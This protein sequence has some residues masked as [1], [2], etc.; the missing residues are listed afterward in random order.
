M[1]TRPARSFER[2]LRQIIEAISEEVA[3]ESVERSVSL[4]RKWTDPDHPSSP[5]VRQALKLDE[6]YLRATHCPAPI[7]SVY[8]YRVERIVDELDAHPES[9]MKAL[10]SLHAAVGTMTHTVSEALEKSASEVPKLEHR[11]CQTLLEQVEMI[12]EEL[13]DLEH[14]IK[15]DMSYHKTDQAVAGSRFASSLSLLPDYL[16]L[17]RSTPL[18]SKAFPFP[19][20]SSTIG[21]SWSSSSEFVQT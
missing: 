1:K 11:D 12:A 3:A 13:T 20:G 7:L 2:A 8:L 9:I 5:S 14:S 19:T 16:I 6:A 10:V 17:H 15:A 18:F 4:V 21:S